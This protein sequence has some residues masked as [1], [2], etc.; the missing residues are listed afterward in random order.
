MSLNRDN[1]AENQF[2]LGYQQGNKQLACII[3]YCEFLDKT[4]RTQEAIKIAQDFFDETLNPNVTN[5][6]SRL[7]LKR[8]VA[9]GKTH[10]FNTV[11]DKLAGKNTLGWLASSCKVFDSAQAEEDFMIRC[12]SHWEKLK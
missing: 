2:E 6:L 7:M 1:E 12:L 4:D 3:P 8:D 10:Y 5:L 9:Q 11:K